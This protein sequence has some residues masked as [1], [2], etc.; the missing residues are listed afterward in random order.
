MTPGYDAVVFSQSTGLSDNADVLRFGLPR[1]SRAAQS[2]LRFLMEAG[3]LEDA[4]RSWDWV[5]GH[6]LADNRPDQ[7][8]CFGLASPIKNQA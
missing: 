3:R 4:R 2:W 5:A 7:R 6:G 8:R 1:D